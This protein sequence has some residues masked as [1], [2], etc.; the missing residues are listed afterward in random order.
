MEWIPIVFIVFKATILFTGMFFAIKW[1]YD[2]DRK[3][4]TEARETQSPTEMRLFAT[5]IIAIALSLIGI[6]YAGFWGNMAEGGRGGALGCAFTLVMFIMSVITKPGAEAILADRSEQADPAA[7]KEE[8]DQSADLE[9]QAEQLRT[10]FAAVLASV[11][12]EKIYLCVAS[13]VSMLTWKY[14]DIASIWLNGGY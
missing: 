8:R 2:Q 14:G 12:R 6:V 9:R 13:V 5:M 11:E 4:K 1:H 3:E 7:P 10:T